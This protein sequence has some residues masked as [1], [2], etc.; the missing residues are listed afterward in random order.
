LA[1]PQGASDLDDLRLT[2]PQLAIMRAVWSGGAVTVAEVVRTLA[3]TRTLAHTTVSTVLT[4]LEKRGLVHCDRSG[5]QLVYSARVGKPETRRAL[6][7][8][9]IDRMFG[10]DPAALVAHL[11]EEHD[12]R[13]EDLAEMTRIV[14][15]GRKK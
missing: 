11:L 15:A 12:V 2:G 3:D 10:G 14:E 4:R 6:V 8:S 13:E 7:R 1:E 5:R 9:F